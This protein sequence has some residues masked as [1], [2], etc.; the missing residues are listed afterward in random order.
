M[1]A[2]TRRRTNE[3]LQKTYQTVLVIKV[4]QITVVALNPAAAANR[5]LDGT[6]L[7]PPSVT[8]P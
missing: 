4:I 5:I 1:P 6:R 2:F 8:K 7:V 3:M